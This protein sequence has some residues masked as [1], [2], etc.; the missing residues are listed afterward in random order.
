MHCAS[1]KGAVRYLADLGGEFQVA[2][3][4]HLPSRRAWRRCPD[5][6][7]WHVPVVWTSVT[8]QSGRRESNSRY[9]LGKLKFCH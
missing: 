3:A 2:P 8:A 7:R 6:R 1:T 5:L 9:Q 4:Q